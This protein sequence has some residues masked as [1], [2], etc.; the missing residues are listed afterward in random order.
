MTRRRRDES[1]WRNGGSDGIIL[2]ER[3]NTSTWLVRTNMDETEDEANGSDD[4]G[5]NWLMEGKK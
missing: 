4:M 2:G 5:R 1:G 3:D